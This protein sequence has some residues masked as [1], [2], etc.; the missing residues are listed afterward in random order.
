MASIK[1]L[2]DLN[3]NGN[4]IQNFALQTLS[5]AQQPD[6]ATP[7]L[8]YYDTTEEAIFVSNGSD[9]T[10]AGL[11]VDGSTITESSGTISVGTI[12]I[13]K[14]DGLQT[15]LNGKVD[16][17]QVLTNVPA[18]A[19]FTDVNVNTS[20]LNSRLSEIDP[21]IG[22]GSGTE[23]ING[24]LAVSG[25]TTTLDTVELVVTDNIITLNAG[26]TAPALDAGIEVNRGSGEAVP[27]VKWDESADR[28][29]FTNDGTNYHNLPLSGEYAAGDITRVNAGEGLGGGGTSGTVTLTN[30]YHRE[31]IGPVEGN[32]AYEGFPQAFSLVAP[33]S[34]EVTIKEVTAS[35]YQFVI[36]DWNVD[37]NTGELKVF[38]PAGSE[39]IVTVSGIRA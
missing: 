1:Y 13:A 36:T 20:N 9:F 18:N 12:A 26:A 15:E 37:L 32:D 21:I 6:P 2:A 4:E 24:N 31:V 8:I 25:T 19:V 23:T 39:F 34:M 29:T 28:W 33:E 27:A 22:T 7:G 38:L 10:R 30:A 16:D 3:L 11:T 35:G 14:V 17:S 5:T